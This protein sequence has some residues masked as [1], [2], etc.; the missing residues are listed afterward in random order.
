MIID[1]I[2]HEV[3]C[4][5]VHPTLPYVAIAGSNKFFNIW[6]YQTKEKIDIEHK[7]ESNADPTAMEYTP[8]GES[9]IVG[10][11]SGSVRFLNLDAPDLEQ[12]QAKVALKDVQAAGKTSEKNVH[13]ITGIVVSPDSKMFATMDRDCGVC[14]FKKDHKFQDP[15]EPIEWIFSGKRR[16]HDIEITSIAFGESLDEKDEE[17]MKLRLFSVGRDRR[18]FEYDVYRSTESGLVVA[19]L[20]KIEQE[21]MPTAAIWYPKTDCKEDLLLTVNDEYKMKVWNVSTQSSRKTVLG[22]TY[23]GEIV[24]L[25]KVDI[26]G[27]QDKFLYYSTQEKVVGL[28]KLPLDGNPT[29]TMGLIAHPGKVVDICCTS[30]GKYM[31]TTGGKDLAINMWKIDVG[32]IDEAI[33]MGGEGIEPFI[34]LIEGGRD[35]QTYLDMKDFFY[36]SMIRAKDENTTKTRKL[37]GTVPLEE[38]PNLMRA[39][40]HYPTEQEIENMIDEVKYSTFTESGQ[41]VTSFDLDTFVRLFVNHRPVYG[42]GKPHIEKAFGAMLGGDPKGSIPRDELL[43]K[44]Q[45]EGEM[46]SVQDIQNY[47]Y[48]LVGEKDFKQAI[49]SNEINAEQFS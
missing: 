22:P 5:S 35:G 47:L 42:I 14:L 2:K 16:T 12:Q 36:Y 11:S 46:I 19:G 3:K 40:G 31:F 33:A 1:S 32:P 34:N 45:R 17:E 39:M 18:L 10:Y 23:G 25:K 29:K 6:N 30:D 28:L 24:K 27:N 37:D 7:P 8:D 20:F 49:A 15:R 21:S 4:I 13:C 48:L 38:L 26:E 41:K 9:L 43:A 44:M